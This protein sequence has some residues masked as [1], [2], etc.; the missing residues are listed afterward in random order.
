MASTERH[1][2]PIAGKRLVFAESNAKVR[3]E[4]RQQHLQ[5]QKEITRLEKQSHTA[6]TNI[7][8]YQQSLKNTWR[9][10]EQQRKESPTQER[11]RRASER[12]D[13]YK[14]G[15]MFST[16][17]KLSV[18]ASTKDIYQ[19]DSKSLT[20][21]D[22]FG[23]CGSDAASDAKL[24]NS[25]GTTTPSSATSRSLL[26]AHPDVRNSPY[27]SSPF[28]F[29]RASPPVDQAEV[30]PMQELP[31]VRT[32]RGA[33]PLTRSLTVPVKRGSRP[34]TRHRS[35]EKH[36]TVPMATEVQSMVD[37]EDRVQHIPL[38]S[39]STASM[40]HTDTDAKLRSN[41]DL[42]LPPISALESKS[43]TK[44][45][46]TTFNKKTLLEAAQTMNF[47]AGTKSLGP[48]TFGKFYDPS[49][50]P[51]LVIT[52]MDAREKGP[53]IDATKLEQLTEEERER[54]SEEEVSGNIIVLCPLEQMH[55]YN[56]LQ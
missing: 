50:T 46:S 52:A 9:K 8:N 26:V 51:A 47:S 32:G 53:Q 16:A 15:L 37:L 23:S 21:L 1:G 20:R 14:K 54:L 27:I 22:E 44:V 4:L 29:R 12:P 34:P 30:T 17:T 42:K 24:A 18:D 6:T 35:M 13:Q 11:N 5:L 25:L 36:V 31:H 45:P 41:P 7:S 56:N 33:Y 38:G 55:S 3:V 43:V 39:R 10:R 40:L 19:N 48:K 49:S 2:S 28:S